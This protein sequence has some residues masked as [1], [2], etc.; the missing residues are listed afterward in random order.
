MGLTFASLAPACSMFLIVLKIVMC[1]FEKNCL[2]LTYKRAVLE[3]KGIMPAADIVYFRGGGMYKG[4]VLH[5][6]FL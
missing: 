1:L 2:I 4:D 6:P 3:N 5:R